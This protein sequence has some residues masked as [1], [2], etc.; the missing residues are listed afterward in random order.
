[1]TNAELKEAVLEAATTNHIWI[2]AFA[3]INPSD[4]TIM[5]LGRA[6]MRMLKA[7]ANLHPSFH[8]SVEGDVTRMQELTPTLY[9]SINAS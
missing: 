3:I 1:M 6:V 5:A 8:G 2:S 4:E 9:L 7:K